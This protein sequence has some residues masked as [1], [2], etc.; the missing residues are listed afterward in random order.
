M[1]G[2]DV[3]IIDRHIAYL[4]HAFP[5]VDIEHL[6]VIYTMNVNN[7]QQTISDLREQGAF[8]DDEPDL[9]FY[10]GSTPEEFKKAPASAKPSAWGNAVEP[11][12]SQRIPISSGGSKP[13]VIR[14]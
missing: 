10:V 13:A 4:D 5:T 8:F 2:Y 7:L 14:P 3:P 12:V 1:Q 11:V 6:E 9:E